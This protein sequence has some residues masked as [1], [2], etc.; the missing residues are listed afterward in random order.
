MLKSYCEVIYR[1]H[2]LQIERDEYID[3]LKESTNIY[4]ELTGQKI[5]IPEKHDY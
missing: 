3:P 5:Y 1:D 4:L 2:K